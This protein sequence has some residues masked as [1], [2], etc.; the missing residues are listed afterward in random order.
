MMGAKPLE[1][2]IADGAAKV[3]GD[4]GILKKIAA[5]M[6]DFDPRFE[7]LPGT[8]LTAPEPTKAR[9][10]R[11][12]GRSDHGGIAS[13]FGVGAIRRRVASTISAAAF[14]IGLNQPRLA[15]RLE[16]SVDLRGGRL[17]R[18]VDGA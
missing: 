5:T 7:I 14:A 9:C 13:G 15:G 17:V 8:K 6:V 12:R 1:A 3:Q 2:Q 18:L 10:L 16:E 11:G 4:A